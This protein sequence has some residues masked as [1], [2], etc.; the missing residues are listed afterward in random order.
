M[1]LGLCARADI[2]RR[3]ELAREVLSAWGK[4]A[5][6]TPQVAPELVDEIGGGDPVPVEEMDA[7]T[8]VTV[9]GDGTILW[10]LMRNPE[11]KVLGV[12]EGE[13]G[14]LTEVSPDRIG[15]ALE[16]VYDGDYF[17]ETRCKL[18]VSKEGEHLGTCTNEMA[19]KT[20]KPSKILT[21]ELSAD[22]HVI[23]NVRADGLIVSTPTGSTSYAMSAG[24]PLVHPGLEAMLVV[25]LAPFRVSLRPI[26][27]PVT[28]TVTVT[29]TEEGK[30]GAL[31]LDGQ[32]EFTLRPGEELSITRSS[33]QAR[34]VRFE[35]HFYSRM[36]ELFG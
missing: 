19:V 11:A 2:P 3:V 22:D 7:D 21:F 34:F 33:E 17:V 4:I 6:S 18:A 8:L 12:N 5:E 13:L 1:K 14:Y 10:T 16:R 15:E 28:T 23:D 31:A 36:R 35:P 25:P 9:G 32:E 30:T 27:L 26:V 29:L 20:P 24:G